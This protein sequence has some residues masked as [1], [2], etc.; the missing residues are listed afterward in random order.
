MRSA[1]RHLCQHGIEALRPQKVNN[2]WRKPIISPRVAADLRKLAIRSGTYGQFD[3]AT[4]I[5]WDPLWDAP[6]AKPIAVK[7]ANGDSIMVMKGGNF[8]GI[9]SIRPPKETKRQRTREARA[10]KIE[11]LVAGMDQKIE[12]YR[13]EREA[14]KPPPGIEEEFKKYMKNSRY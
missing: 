10:Q 1:L 8:G 6:K 5:G 9:Q 7:D 2:K 14:K 11:A 13:L 3:T 12:E 4:G